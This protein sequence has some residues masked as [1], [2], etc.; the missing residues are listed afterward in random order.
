MSWGTHH[1]PSLALFYARAKQTFFMPNSPYELNL[2]SSLLSIFHTSMES[3]HPDPAIFTDVAIETWRMLD[4]SLRRFVNA[5]FNNVGNNRVV[6]GIIAGIFFALLGSVPPLVLNFTRH[7]SRWLRLLAFPG[8][9]IGLTILVSAFNGICLGIYIFGDYRQ[10]RKFELARPPISRPVPITTEPKSASSPESISVPGDVVDKS[11]PL[12]PDGRIAAHILHVPTPTSDDHSSLCTDEEDDDEEDDISTGDEGAAQIHISPAFYENSSVEGGLVP[13]DYTFPSRPAAVPDAKGDAG[14]PSSPMTPDFTMT[15]T[16]IHP[17]DA[18]SI[19]INECDRPDFVPSQRQRI[20]AFD[21][22]SLP[23]LHINFSRPRRPSTVKYD[24]RSRSSTIPA[25]PPLTKPSDLPPVLP[26]IERQSSRCDI[27]RWRLQTESTDQIVFTSPSGTPVPT[28]SPTARRFST[29][30]TPAG[31][32][33]TSDYLN[34]PYNSHILPRPRERCQT[35]KSRRS[36]GTTG[37]EF[38][39]TETQVQKRN[40]LMRAVPAFA[41][42]L[43]K[44]LSPVIRRGQWEIVVRSAG[45]GFLLS[46]VI[47]GVVLAIPVPK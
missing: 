7:Q 9:F 35:L 37:T 34:N 19:D 39:D 23:P 27:K 29:S 21:F 47:V 33:V 32:G 30:I 18:A 4:E 25:T 40:K 1:S 10:L 15:A 6:C 13:A 12:E 17:F 36:M 43:T 16:F 31:V 26:P 20:D 42:P 11:Q 8:L 3:P 24:S 2:P 5:Q 46:W 44:V 28:S 22:D 45:I 14:D 38:S 41:V